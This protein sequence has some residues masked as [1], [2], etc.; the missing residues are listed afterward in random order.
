M[1]HLLLRKYFEENTFVKD[2]IESYN[3]FIEW[4]LQRLI[5]EVGPVSP[6]VIPPD[7]EMVEFK[8]GQV[9]IGKPVFVEA[10]GAERSILPSEARLR[11]LTYA[12]SIFLE[13]ALIVDGKEREFAEV[14]IAELPVLLKSKLCNLHGLDEEGL[15]KAGEDPSDP[16]GYFVVNGTER[17]LIQ[18]E[19]L[20][21]NT[22]FADVD[23]SGP[24]THTGRIYSSSGP[25]RISHVV[26]RM[27]NGLLYVTF[28]NVRRIPFVV[29]MKALGVVSD[30][31]VVKCLNIDTSDDDIYVNLCE[32]LDTKSQEDA[33]DFVA[34][35]MKLPQGKEQRIGRVNY[36][37]DS[38][39]LP[40]VGT[41]EDDRLKKAKLLGRVARKILMLKEGKI[42]KDC[43]DHYANKRVRLSGDLLEDLFRA[44]LKAF[45]NDMLY[46]FQRG[47]RRGSI[48]PISSI[49]R[50]K[51]LT[52][53]ILSAI[54]T[55]AWTGGRQGVSQRL[56]RSNALNTLS[57]LQRVSSLLST[58]QE[59]FEARE[60]HPT[61]WGRLCPVESP[62]GKNIG[63]RKNLA[64][65]ASITPQLSSEEITANMKKVE[66][67]GVKNE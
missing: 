13:V 2:N 47:V 29:L 27:K 35:E 10:D 37:L 19:D 49:V 36:A 63:L 25:Y 1:D 46:I 33:Q 5:D 30:K 39:L 38:L 21:P 53:K 28:A 59:N 62:E 41:T 23:K 34:K 51:Y 56:E 18:L 6:A 32:N 67:L 8:F 48:L 57:H 22:I 42:I 9:R 12:A 65:L 24:S 14:Q 7:T 61:H 43:K 58:S 17:A 11:D 3:S 40:H 60:L 50:T 66:E 26:E 20:A 44:N 45:I 54:A 55:G 52:S 4:R 31:E 64:L 16:G 15:I